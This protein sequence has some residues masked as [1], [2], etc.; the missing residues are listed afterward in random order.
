MFQVVLLKLLFLSKKHFIPQH[1][2]RNIEHGTFP[3]NPYFFF[4]SFTY[5]C[6]RFNVIPRLSYLYPIVYMIWDKGG[7]KVG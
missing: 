2:T 5:S 1:G 4:I 7:T 3:P 6:N